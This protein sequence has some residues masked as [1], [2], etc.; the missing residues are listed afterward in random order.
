MKLKMDYLKINF[1]HRNSQINFEETFISIEEFNQKNTFEDYGI[2]KIIYYQNGIID[3]NDGPAVIIY[4]NDKIIIEKYYEC[5][6]LSREDG[7]AVINYCDDKIIRRKYY[8]GG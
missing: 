5:G 7:P 4:H 2:H 8:C 3:R 6:F 1:F